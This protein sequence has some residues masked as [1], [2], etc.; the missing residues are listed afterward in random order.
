MLNIDWFQPYKHRQYSIGVIYLAILNLPRAV[1]FKRENIILVGLVPGPSEPSLTMNTYLAPLVA[2]LSTLWDG[3]DIV[4]CDKGKQKIR[5]ALLC[6]GCDLP[7]GRKVCGF[8]SY[9]ANLGCTRCYCEFSTGVFGQQ[10]YSG[11]NRASWKR[12][13]NEQHRDH[14][15]TI[16]ACSTKTAR[17][18]LE[19]EF[20]CRY[21]QLLQLPY[22]DVVRM[23]IID[24]MHNLYLGT[25]KYIFSGI[26]TKDDMIDRVSLK[27]INER[28]LSLIVSSEV[29]FNRLPAC[30][31]YPSSLT[32]EQ[33]MLWVN[34]YS[35]FCLYNLIPS[36]HLECWRKFVLA[37]RILCQKQ[38]LCDEIKL[39]DSLLLEFCNQ[40]QLLYGADKV[41]PNIHL[42]AHLTDCIVDYGPMSSFWLFSFERFNGILGDEPTNNRSIEVQLM[43]RFM[44]D[45]AHLQLLNSIP[46]ASTDVTKAFSHVVMNHVFSFTSQK[47]LDNSSS[48]IHN[49]KVLPATK[50]VIAS[51][52]EPEMKV[53]R[54]VYLQVYPSVITSHAYFPCSY[55]KMQYVTIDGQKIKAGQFILAKSIF[56]FS[57]S[58]SPKLRPAKVDYFFQHSVQINSTN[59]ISHVFAVVNWPMHHPFRHRIGKPYEIWCSSSFETSDRN[60]ILPMCNYVTL[61]LTAQQ[62][63]ENENVLVT[64]PLIL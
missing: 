18:R 30:M 16:R 15:Q 55:R 43:S 39:A 51:F 36:Q 10:N 35:I 33:W 3:V 13:A 58:N 27:L 23:L 62:T 9:T 60:F 32:A 26:W 31:Q 6:V 38:I 42:H 20:G 49:D 17:Q 8:L 46:D 48:A 24:P 59:C 47:H 64:I 21:S 61:L 19:S 50:C 63:I 54:S 5:C 25:A 40:F 1:R 12:R 41:T 45:N 56:S 28:I 53:L 44:K 52:S 57:G 14:V 2:D 4:T 22:F 11:F 29:R 7:A 34:Y 37:S